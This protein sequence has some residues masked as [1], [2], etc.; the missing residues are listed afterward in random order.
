MTAY[1]HDPKCSG[2]PHCST[3]MAF[4]M[5]HPLQ[6]WPKEPR[7]A[8]AAMRVG[9]GFYGAAERKTKEEWANQTGKLLGVGSLFLDQPPDPY[10]GATSRAPRPSVPCDDPNYQPHGTAPDGYAIALAK[11]KGR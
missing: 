8:Q 3:E 4:L 6:T 2:C 10:S 5:D 7:T 1:T 9:I 11:G